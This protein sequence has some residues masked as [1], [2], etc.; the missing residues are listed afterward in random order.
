MLPF[1][2]LFSVSKNINTKKSVLEYRCAETLVNISSVPTVLQILE[3]EDIQFKEHQ[4]E[5]SVLQIPQN[6][7]WVENYLGIFQ[8]RQAL[9]SPT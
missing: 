2:W 8:Y 6:Y 4:K 3:T 1:C 9:N 5:V 7:T